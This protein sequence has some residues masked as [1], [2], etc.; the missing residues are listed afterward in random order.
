[1]DKS[2]NHAR[3]YEFLAKHPV[4]VL[5]T[6]DVNAEPHG[7]VIYYSVEDNFN[8]VFTTKRDTKKHDNLQHNN[9]AMVT[10]YEPAS[11]T[12]VQILAT[13][14]DIT[15]TVKGQDSFKHALAASIRT[16]NTAVP[17]ISKL[18]AGHY[19]AYELKPRQIRIA[20]FSDPNPGSYDMFETIDF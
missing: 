9:H 15:D 2:D 16:S 1:M 7:V 20:V 19:V 6:V 11:Q 4:G 13:A 5:S 18:S 3:I 14:T 12:T 8:I 10:V 17:P